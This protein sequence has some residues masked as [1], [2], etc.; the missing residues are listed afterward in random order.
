MKKPTLLFTITDSMQEAFD[1][2]IAQIRKQGY[3]LSHK[4]G[5]PVVCMYRGAGGV[6]CAAGPFIP[7]EHVKKCEMH[8]MAML[9]NFG[10]VAFKNR[11]L[12]HLLT[13]LQGIHDRRAYSAGR[14]R[15]HKKYFEQSWKEVAQN[16]NL[17][18]TAP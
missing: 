11:P 9:D 17:K 12:L 10:M 3:K 2:S 18:Y 13:E 1:K 15:A 16:R 4:P 8:T 7:D 5:K 14:S 6:M